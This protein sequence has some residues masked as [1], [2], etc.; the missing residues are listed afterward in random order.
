DGREQWFVGVPVHPDD[1]RA[2]P[3][4]YD[5][6]P[7]PPV[8]LEPDEMRCE[9][10]LFELPGELGHGNAAVLPRD[11]VVS[12]L[13]AR[14]AHADTTARVTSQVSARSPRRKVSSANPSSRAM[15]ARLTS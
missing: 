12:G 15:L 3:I 14:V 13:V 4:A 5:D 9:S 8:G 11:Q 10:G 7:G 2:V 1:G 6:E